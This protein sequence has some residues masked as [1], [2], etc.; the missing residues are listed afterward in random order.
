M[1]TDNFPWYNN[2]F[3]RQRET[4]DENDDDDTCHVLNYVKFENDIVNVKIWMSEI[5][6]HLTALTNYQ[7]QV[8][9]LKLF[10][11]N[12]QYPKCLSLNSKYT[13]QS[14][15]YQGEMPQY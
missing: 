2:P 10:C 14:Q 15:L 11:S 3:F 12:S 9:L 5:F 8:T 1:Q 13:S 7:F 4:N 6:L